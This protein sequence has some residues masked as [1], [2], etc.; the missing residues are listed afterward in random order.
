MVATNVT[1]LLAVADAMAPFLEAACASAPARDDDGSVGGDI[2]SSNR[3]CAGHGGHIINVC[4]RR[5]GLDVLASTPA[6][7]ARTISAAASSTR[8]DLTELCTELATTRADADDAG[9]GG[10][11]PS[12]NGYGASKLLAHVATMLLAKEHANAGSGVHVSAVCPG[13][14]KTRMT[15]GMGMTSAADASKVIVALAVARLAPA[16]TGHFWT[17]RGVQPPDPRWAL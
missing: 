17:E 2:G 7:L 1:G 12:K 5:G 14:V 11:W 16:Q 8:S 4:S 15:G 3:T 10:G 6:L 9:V 13:F